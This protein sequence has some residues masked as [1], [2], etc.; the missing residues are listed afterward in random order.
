[1]EVWHFALCR[2]GTRASESIQECSFSP[3]VGRGWRQASTCVLSCRRK[4][5]CTHRAE[6]NHQTSHVKLESDFNHSRKSILTFFE[7]QKILHFA[8]RF[9]LTLGCWDVKFAIF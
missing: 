8:L 4:F 3:T 2:E 9:A 5:K 1:M 7:K 6:V